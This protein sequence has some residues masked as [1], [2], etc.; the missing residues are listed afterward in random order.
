MAMDS[1]LIYPWKMLISHGYGSWP[2]GKYGYLPCQKLFTNPLRKCILGTPQSSISLAFSKKKKQSPAIS[3]PCRPMTIWEKHQGFNHR[4][5]PWAQWQF[6]FPALFVSGLEDGQPQEGRWEVHL[7]GLEVLDQLIHRA[8]TLEGVLPR[9]V[10][11]GAPSDQRSTGSWSDAGRMTVDMSRNDPLRLW[12]V[13][14]VNS[15][16]TQTI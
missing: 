1:S 16:E 9:A 15:Y 12:Y 8:A 7:S 10:G 14:Y 3:Y 6:G 4:T 13:W 2:E 11:Q 5:P